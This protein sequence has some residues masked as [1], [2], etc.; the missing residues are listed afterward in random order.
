MRAAWYAKNGAARDVLV[1]G[2]LPTPEPG[3]GEVRV[4]LATSGVNPSD[5]K[6][7]AGRPLAAERIVPHSDGGGTIDA[8][9]AGVPVRRIGE[10]VWIW[11]GQ[12]QRPLGTAAEFIALPAGQAVPLS[13][14]TDFAT[15]ACLDLLKRLAVGP[16]SAV[17]ALR[18]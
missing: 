12:W 4:R 18:L 16:R 9:G 13:D 10:R 2:D 8:V 15:A 7:R 17:V 3:P 1:V 5:V 6:S 11:N 14:A